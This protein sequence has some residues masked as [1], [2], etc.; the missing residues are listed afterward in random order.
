M[1]GRTKEKTGWS[2]SGRTMSVNLL[3][4]IRRGK[5]IFRLNNRDYECEAGDVMLIPRGAFYS[6]HTETS[7]EYTF[8]HFDGELNESDNRI[9][10]NLTFSF[11]AF[12]NA[13]YGMQTKGSGLLAFDH[14]IQ[15]GDKLD[16][17]EIILTK[18]ANAGARY[19]GKAQ[20]AL[21][22]AFSE[23]MLNISK[24]YCVQL[25]QSD[26]YPPAVNKILA[27]IND[28]YIG[29]IGLEKISAATGISKQYCMRIFKKFLHSTIADYITSLR[30]KH[31]QYLLRHTYMNVNQTSDYLGFSSSS[32]FSRTFKK[33]FG[34]PPSS[35][36]E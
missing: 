33:Y 24:I 27:Y 30:M 34:L 6:P 29:D 12:G 8:F 21:A 35:Y 28:N 32:Y 4:I 7:C 11:P 3:V 23:I 22:L 10:E 19:G 26:P 20:L 2:H 9:D 5:C 25:E 18:C 36:N 16:E 31:A 1:M 13:L 17:L 15:I 14:H